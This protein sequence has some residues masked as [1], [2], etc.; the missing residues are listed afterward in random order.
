MKTMALSAY[1]FEFGTKSNPI[2]LGEKNAWIQ[3]RPRWKQVHGVNCVEVNTAQQE[4]GEVDA[5][6]TRQENFPIAVVTADCVPLF[7]MRKDQTAVAAIHAGWRGTFARI[8]EVFFKNLQKTE[9]KKFT[10]PAEWKA[11]LGPCIRACCYE[12]SADLIEQFAQEFSP[13]ARS[14][15]E[16]TP[17]HLDLIALNR[18][19]LESMGL[20]EIEVHPDCTFCKKD[21][22]GN[23]Q[24]FSYR[25]GDRGSRQYSMISLLK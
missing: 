18:S 1:S 12:V 24:Y 8:T 9:G 5:L 6:W 17:R 25:R 21:A 23:E 10:D 19:S 2:P 4:C 11:L 20:S 13:L 7:L 16:P 22:Q 15:I 3:N 14:K